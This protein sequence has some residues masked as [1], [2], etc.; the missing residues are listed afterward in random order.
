[1]GTIIDGAIRDVDEMNN[2][3]FKALARRMCVGHAHPVPIRWNCEVE[4]F[5]RKVQPGQLIHADKHGFLVIPEED[6]Q[7]LLEAARF[8]DDNEC[9]HLISIAR[10]TAGKS[11]DTILREIRE[12]TAAFSKAAVE[13]FQRKGEW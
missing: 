10:N 3:G 8:L 6:E 2:A 1:V 12:G 9:N 11:A 4:V 13:K 5:G 7:G